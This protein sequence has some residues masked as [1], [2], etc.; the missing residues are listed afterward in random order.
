M[1][2]L[3]ELGLAGGPREDPLTYPGAWPARSGLCT[4]TGCCR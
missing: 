2:T 3:E 4:A 1:A